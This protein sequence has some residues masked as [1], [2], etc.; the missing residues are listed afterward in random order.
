MKRCNWRHAA[1]TWMKRQGTVALLTGIVLAG[2]PCVA[3]ADVVGEGDVSPVG[4]TN[5][6]I[7]G[8]VVAGDIIV[9]GTGT[10]D[11]VPVTTIGILTIDVPAFTDPLVSD[12]GY[13]GN[14]ADGIG[15]VTVSGFLSEWSVNNKMSVGVNGQGYLTISGTAVVR[16]NLTGSDEDPD[17]FVGELVGSQGYVTITGLGSQWQNDNLV[18][19]HRGT[20]TITVQTGALLKTAFDAVLGDDATTTGTPDAIGMG[21][22]IVTGTGSQWTVADQMTVGRQGRGEV[23]VLAGGRV[24]AGDDVVFANVSGSYAKAV[25][26]GQSSQFWAEQT[27]TVATTA[28]AQAELYV[29]DLGILRADTSL[30]L[31]QG[32]FLN[33]AGG[34]ILTP[35]ITSSGV[36]RGAG[37]INGTV[38]NDGDIRNAAGIANNRERLL[39]TGTVANNDNIESV[40]GE[41]EFKG[42]VTNNTPNGDIYGKDAIFRFMGAGGLVNNSRLTLDNTLV[43]STNVVNNASLAVVAGEE[44][45]TILGNVTLGGSS[46]LEMELGDDFSQLWVTGDANLGGALRLSLA[47]NYTPMTGDSFEILRSD[48]LTG[49]FGQTIMTSDPGLLWEVDYTGDSVFVTFGATA[50]PVGSGADFNG[51]NIVNELDLAIMMGNYGLGSNPPPLATRAD[52][53]ANGDGVVDGSDFLLYQQQF[54]GPPPVVPA[55]GESVAAVPEPSSLLLAAAAFGLPL[56]MRRRGE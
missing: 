43:E 39:F 16:S 51:D 4:P 7:D 33:L 2:A 14:T 27:M 19:G 36:I 23:Q 5:L 1:T 42:N 20:G 11:P 31:G 45:S 13:I 52:G 55:S 25:I 17:A 10:L 28:G 34:T 54:G 41:M 32:A 49:T 47:P 30:T 38:T 21:T 48:S 44:A 18:V 53:D 12:N 24:R 8:G 26:S 3:F 46:I 6:P 9:G 56:A 22:V 15:Q 37:T 29:N 40:G 35:T 50:P